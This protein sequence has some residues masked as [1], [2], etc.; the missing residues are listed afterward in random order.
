M[1]KKFL[2]KFSLVIL[3]VFAAFLVFSRV[4][5]IIKLNQEAKILE[6]YGVGNSITIESKKLNMFSYGNL[7]SK[8]TVVFMHGL[9]IGDTTI[10]TRPMLDEFTEDYNVCILDRYGNGMSDD[11]SDIQSVDNIINEYRTALNYNGNKAPYVLIAHSISGIY[12]TYWAQKYPEEIKSIIYLDADPAK[13]FVEEGEPNKITLFISKI[14]ANV[15]SLGLQRFCLGEEFIIGEDE[16][17]NFSQ[18]QKRLRTY[19]IYK[20]TY[21][22]ATHSEFKSYY[23]NAKCV[24]EQKAKINIPKLHIVADNMSGDYYD[25]VYSKQ[26]DE[27]FKGKTEEIEAYLVNQKKLMA[28]KIEYMNE[29]KSSVTRISG[30]HCI[31]EY[32]PKEVAN[33]ILAFLETDGKGKYAEK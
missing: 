14:G 24:F 23:K 20:N 2:K 3:I 15:A 27:R 30:P 18:K 21:S 1:K 22:E 13:C 16:N 31:Y 25:K 11:S 28:K 4:N 9:G 26:L 12:A 33:I 6:N 29:E 17:K 8:E 19:L 7:S 5:H 32:K 10:S